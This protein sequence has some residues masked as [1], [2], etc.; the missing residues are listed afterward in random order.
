MEKK[1]TAHEELNSLYKQHKI[2]RARDVVAFARDEKTALHSKF[3]WDDTNAARRY[4]L[5]QARGIIRVHVTMI[6]NGDAKARTRAWVSMYADREKIGGGYR[7]IGNVISNEQLTAKLLEQAWREADQFK[8]RY[9][10]LKEL[11]PIFEAMDKVFGAAS[12]KVAAK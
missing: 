3:C 8:K 2:L 11:L 1:L 4:R 5:I 10:N 12:M 9:E 6:S 7:S